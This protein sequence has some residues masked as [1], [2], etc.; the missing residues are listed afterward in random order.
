MSLTCRFLV[1]IERESFLLFYAVT[2][3]RLKTLSSKEWFDHIRNMTVLHVKLRM[4]VVF[5]IL[6]SVVFFDVM[7]NN[8]GRRDINCTRAWRSVASSRSNLCLKNEST[9]TIW[10]NNSVGGKY[11][12]YLCFNLFL[13]RLSNML[14]HRYALLSECE[15]IR[16]MFN[17]TNC[18]ASLLIETKLRDITV[19][20]TVTQRE[21]R[22]HRKEQGV[23]ICVSWA[24]PLGSF[25]YTIYSIF[26]FRWLFIA[27]EYQTHWQGTSDDL[28]EGN[29]SL[30][31][32]LLV[33][34]LQMTSPQ[35]LYSTCE[36]STGNSSVSN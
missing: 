36:D 15:R 19:A 5:F 17:Q 25:V 26:V 8:P 7:A 1:S 32:V 33:P 11:L 24:E 23:Q 14:L 31:L 30:R 16:L 35:L 28:A 10:L 20:C 34:F 6:I 29:T 22:Y 3:Y 12:N 18:E 4:A 27:I 2:R 21:Q 9:F 13:L